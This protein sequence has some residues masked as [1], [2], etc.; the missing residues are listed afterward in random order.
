[1]KDI[2]YEIYMRGNEKRV[3][4]LKPESISNKDYCVNKDEN[5]EERN[6]YNYSFEIVQ[7]LKNDKHTPLIV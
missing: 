5:K 2:E 7:V 6:D 4:F 1:M 3:K